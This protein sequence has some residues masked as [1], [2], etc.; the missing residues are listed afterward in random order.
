MGCAASQQQPRSGKSD[1]KAASSRS[2]RRKPFWV[3]GKSHKGIKFLKEL[4]HRL[5]SN[6]EDSSIRL[7]RS[8]FLRSNY[9]SHIERRQSLEARE[10]A[11]ESIF[12]PAREAVQLLSKSSRAIAVFTYGW[13]TPD[14]PDVTGEYLASVQRFLRSELGTPIVAVFWDFLSLPQKPRSP[15]EAEQFADA[16]DCMGDLYASA[17]GTMVMRHRTIPAR[18]VELDGLVTVIVEAPHTCMHPS[19]EHELRV[20]EEVS[21]ERVCDLCDGS[22]APMYSCLACDVDICFDCCKESLIGSISTNEPLL[23]LA[24]G[25]T[26]LVSL[27]LLDGREWRLQFASQAEAEAAVAQD[28][29]VAG[30]SNAAC[31]PLFNARPY[32]QRGWTNFESGVSA[33]VICR[34]SAYPQLRGLLENLP[35]KLVE[36]DGPSPI[37]AELDTSGGVGTHSASVRTALATATFT[38]K[39]DKQNVT[40]LYHEYV[41]DMCDA[42]VDSGE[43]PQESY[44]GQR[45]GQG[46]KHGWGVETCLDGYSYRGDWKN[47]KSHGKGLMYFPSGDVFEGDWR[48]NARTGHGRFASVDGLVY[49]GA[50]KDDEKEGAGIQDWPEKATD[51]RFYDGEWHDDDQHGRGV[52]QY[53]DGRVYEGQFKRCLHEGRG[54]MWYP[55]GDVYDGEWRA[56]EYHGGGTLYISSETDRRRAWKGEYSGV[57]MARFKRGAPEGAGIRWC[58]DGTAQ[59]LHFD[60]A[61]SKKR[62][63]REMTLAEAA[64]MAS[65]LRMKPPD[66]SVAPPLSEL[67]KASIAAADERGRLPLP[68]PGS[69][70]APE[71]PPLDEMHRQV[72]SVTAVI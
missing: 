19:H 43:E 65:K 49:V 58:A 41:N 46:R 60:A 39:G 30:L 63:L 50:W 48:N 69:L 40:T 14:D 72:S 12:L 67:A 10:R 62:L 34:V 11:G 32:A 66:A 31:F 42:L 6:L 3:T 56:D 17:L 29:S 37:I 25:D 47:D 7:I 26:N 54:T 22:T 1:L 57:E 9:L 52:L 55:N 71:L 28:L 61:N 8:D 16:L 24:F 20:C 5:K 2:Q 70:I 35:P 4:D 51:Y 27:T 53:T 68:A 45:D 44:E 64:K 13:T 33:E 21:K 23:R 59:K 15:E 36:I 18:P 38:G